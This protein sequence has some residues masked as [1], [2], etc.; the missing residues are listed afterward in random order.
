[1][2]TSKFILSVIGAAAVGVIIGSVLSSGKGAEIAERIKNTAGD[3][4]GKKIKEGS[5][6]LEGSDTAKQ[7]AEFNQANSPG[8][9]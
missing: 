5:E 7:R 9:A 8:Q 2:N 3:W 4:L 1:M 6:A